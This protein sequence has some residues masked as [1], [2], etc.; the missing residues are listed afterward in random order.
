MAINKAKIERTRT[1]RAEA[2]SKLHQFI[3][4]L[5]EHASDAERN[6]NPLM[7]DLYRTVLAGIYESK[8]IDRV[9][10]KLTITLDLTRT[11]V[12]EGQ[13]AQKKLQS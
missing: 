9:T 6:D 11:T 10:N 12:I 8:G 2:I 7:A 4:A 13:E 5:D 3:A 1:Q